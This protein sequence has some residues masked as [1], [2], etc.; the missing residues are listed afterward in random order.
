M[1]PAY[2]AP[3]PPSLDFLCLAGERLTSGI[4]GEPGQRVPFAGKRGR[5]GRARGTWPCGRRCA[6]GAVVGEPRTLVPLDAGAA[7][8][9]RRRGQVSAA[10]S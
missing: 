7:G 9:H 1:L 2:H 5:S 8:R 4:A 3:A 10:T 6:S